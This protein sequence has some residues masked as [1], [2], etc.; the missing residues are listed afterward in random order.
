VLLGQQVPV[1]DHRSQE[2]GGVG[3]PVGCAFFAWFSMGVFFSTCAMAVLFLGKQC[4][5]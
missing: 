2:G 3:F 4:I 1:S 5:F